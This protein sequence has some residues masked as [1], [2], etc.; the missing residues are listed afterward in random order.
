M[1]QAAKPEGGAAPAVPERGGFYLGLAVAWT[2]VCALAWGVGGP[3]AVRVTSPLGIIGAGFAGLATGAIL[4]ALGQA[5]LLRHILFHPERW[6][7]SAVVAVAAVGAVVFGGSALGSPDA[8]WVGGAAGVGVALGLAQWWAVM[9]SM[10]VPN[11][12]APMTGLAWI[13]AVVFSAGA[14]ALLE[15]DA[16]TWV[17]LGGAFGAMTGVAMAWIA[18][19]PPP[20]E[21]E[22]PAH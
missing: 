11:W 20:E 7:L 12:W 6:V 15:G 9:G 16:A 17:L 5:F 3:V 8:A 4:A 21:P 13:G 14:G 1:N 10:W 2:L 18:P 22:A 19:P